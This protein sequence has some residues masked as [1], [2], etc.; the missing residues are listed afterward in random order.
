MAACVFSVMR[1]FLNMY[2]MYYKKDDS[3]TL[4]AVLDAAVKTFATLFFGTLTGSG[5]A[6]MGKIASQHCGE[7]LGIAE[8]ILAEAPSEY[9]ADTAHTQP[10][11]RKHR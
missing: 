1:V 7:K 8:L 9:D 10:Q 5:T 2:N 6:Y 4:I 3:E 11:R